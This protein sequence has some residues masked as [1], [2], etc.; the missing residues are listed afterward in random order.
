MKRIHELP[1]ALVPLLLLLTSA[2]LAGEQPEHLGIDVSHYSGAVDWSQVAAAGYSFAFVKATEGEDA[3]DPRFAG[4]WAELA[5]TGLARGAYHFYV[6]HDDPE[7]Q[8]R[9]FLATVPFH[10]SDLLPVVDVES[11]AGAPPPAEFAR[12]LRRFLD[13]VERETGA[14]PILY[15]G[16]RFWQ[17]HLAGDFSDYP[18]WI[19]EYQVDTAVVPDGFEGWT[20]WQW[21]GDVAVPG[22]EKKAD[23]SRL[24]PGLSLDVLRMPAAVP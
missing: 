1:A 3:A 18:L 19:A 8:A 17:T 10:Q 2:T 6:A 16:P 13:L 24:A 14:R 11:P 12:Q 15:T 20:L 5:G 4:H 23:V 21:E 7:V 22:V 9:F